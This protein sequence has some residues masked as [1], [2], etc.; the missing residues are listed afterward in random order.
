MALNL[1][2]SYTMP[3]DTKQSIINAAESL[4]DQ[5][6]PYHNFDHIRDVLDAAEHI[7]EKCSAES[8]AVDEEV[9]FYA[10]LFHDAGYHEDHEANG[11]DTKEAYSAHL[12]EQ[13]L[14]QHGI[15]DNNIKKIKQAIN[16]THIEGVCQS[17]EDKVVK[18]SDLSNLCA[19]YSSFKATSLK[20]LAEYNLMNGLNIKWDDW[21]Q[22]AVNR[23]EQY[24]DDSIFLTSDSYNDNGECVFIV[25]TRSNIEKLLAD[26]HA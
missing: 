5:S 22:I 24:L 19:E 16:C 1:C 23:L 3:I 21:K 6:L 14:K 25:N 17:N 18:N 12:A 13:V 7:L 11:F 9:V 8:I 26:N 15:S 10:L 2:S 20:L 4:Y